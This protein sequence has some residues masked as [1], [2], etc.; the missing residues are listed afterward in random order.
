[1]N[2]ANR[3][4]NNSIFSV[5]S[6]GW[7][8]A[9]G[10][11]TTRYLVQGLGREAYGIF[12][13]ALTVVGYF[14]ILDLG[15]NNAAVK[16]VAEQHAK[17]DYQAVNRTIWTTVIFF[18]V[19]GLVGSL[20]GI[21]LANFLIRL[22]QVSSA[23]AGEARFTFYVVAL[24]LPLTLVLAA[25]ASIPNA[26]QRYDISSKVTISIMT[27]STLLTLALLAA[28]YHL[29]A[30]ILLQ[31]IVTVI[32]LV[33]NMI[34]TKRLLPQLTWRPVFD[35]PT[36][37]MLA[38]FGLFTLVT[39]VSTL[40]LFQFDRL[41]V[42]I[43]LGASL[44]TAYV[45]PLNL[46]TQ[47]HKVI[48]AVAGVLFPV[49]SALFSTGKTDVLREL[50]QR[51]VKVTLIISTFLC[52]V[53][54]VFSYP[55]LEIWIDEEL[56]LTS[57]WTLKFLSFGWYFISISIVAT[58]FLVGFGKPNLVAFSSLCTVVINVIGLLLLI[59]RFGIIGAALTSMLYFHTLGLMYYVEKDLLGL[60][61]W[62]I[63]YRVYLKVWLAGLLLGLLFYFVALPYVTSL[64]H[65]IGF[66]L[67]G[68]SIYLIM[69]LGLGLFDRDDR[70]IF[71]GY[72]GQLYQPKRL[73]KPS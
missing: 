10:F 63:V 59:P 18:A 14:A 32:S 6:L 52:V 36:F 66:V 11:I 70:R 49:S 19:V 23:L 72:L 20:M 45:V 65:L 56:A 73:T 12:A 68:G 29:R 16:Y 17:R 22:F 24:G 60:N 53:L 54:I 67:A 1:M 34:L 51:A 38:S 62:R 5:L 28:G 71:V 15:L 61:S 21:L 40:F 64:L 55:I 46:A 26:L 25:F 44:V 13:L 48:I 33:V 39:R 30:I 31:L 42:G 2:L 4:I 43:I 35:W 57:S 27:I 9:L 69:I 7:S 37:K 8:L 41:V 3:T 47:I 58:I 50:Y